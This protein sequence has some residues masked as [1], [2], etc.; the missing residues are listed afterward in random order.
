MSPHQN[1]RA[2]AVK[3]VNQYGLQHYKSVFQVSE[4]KTGIVLKGGAGLGSQCPG[5]QEGP[6][7]ILQEFSNLFLGHGKYVSAVRAIDVQS[8]NNPLEH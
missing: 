1:V 8:V 5:L 3:A 2:S 6:K 7:I 4:V